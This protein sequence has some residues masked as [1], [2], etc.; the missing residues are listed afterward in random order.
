MDLTTRNNDSSCSCKDGYYEDPEGFYKCLECDKSCETCSGPGT[1]LTC[2]LVANRI[3]S[4]PE[5]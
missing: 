3:N 1:C 4:P 2:K 5:C